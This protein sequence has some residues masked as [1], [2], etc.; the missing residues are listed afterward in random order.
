MCS[1]LRIGSMLLV[2]ALALI[3]CGAPAAPAAPPAV[4]ATTAVAEEITAGYQEAP[5][6]AAQVAAGQLP[7][8][9]ER[10]P[11]NPLVVE[12][13]EQIGV[14]GG[15]W[16]TALRGGAD[17]AWLVRTIAYENLVTWD[18][19]F[20]G[21]VPAVAE[22]YEVSDDATTFTFYLRQGMKWS[23]G[24]PFTTDDLL[25]WHELF[26]DDEINPGKDPTYA[27]GGEVVA[28]EKVDDTTVRFQ[29]AEPNGLFLLRLA[30]PDAFRLTQMPKHY[31]SQFHAAY[32]PEADNLAKEQGYEN[33]QALLRARW[34]SSG[35]FNDA[36][37][38]V[39]WA[40]K[41]TAGY[42]EATS[43]LVA[44]RNPYYYKVDTAG[45]QLP[46]IDRVVYSVGADAQALLL[47]AL[48]GEIDLMSR[49][50]NTIDNKAVLFDN[51]E[52]GAYRFYNLTSVNA[53][54]AAIM[55]NLA[56]ADPAHRELYN[57]KDFRIGLSHAIN[58]QEIIDTVFVGQ[59]VPYQV[60]PHPASEYYNEQAATQYTE[61][62]VT[63]AGEYLDK[64]GLTAK[65]GEGFRLLPDGERLT[66][67]VEVIN[68]QGD[69]VKIMELVQRHW[70]AVGVD[71]E[72]NVA[73]RSLVQA[74]I[75]SNQYDAAILWGEGGGGQ[76]FVL[77]PIWFVPMNV[78]S[79]S[80]LWYYWYIGD[81]RGEEPPAEIRQSIDLYR[82]VQATADP[83]R[84]SE[85]LQ[86]LVQQTADNFVAIGI[87]SPLDGYGIVK[88]A[89][90]NVPETMWDS[91]TW[92]QP[93]AA[94]ASQFFFAAE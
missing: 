23:D 31:L 66:V 19:E 55:L 83:A 75:D 88:N 46:Y 27:P 9:E 5:D 35:R 40:W 77:A 71:T 94:N 10:L 4:P 76:D 72:L 42:N 49:H 62:D 63:L 89:M 59:G 6:L 82:E 24:E 48:N 61:Y 45:N 60:A 54:T 69:W 56:N 11:K 67:R 8:L 57:N 36:N 85:L 20:R 3:A 87:S 43:Q 80:V 38:P 12:P 18:L 34:E 86:Q 64:A 28:L 32:N 39:L 53:N 37:M 92:P 73:D 78:H 47:N 81:E 1:R 52:Q 50:F 68:T 2:L 58:R 93:G 26:L 79:F 25:F 70:E 91:Y 30:T 29:F 21:V 14:Y 16:R 7:P 51:Q 65:D 84:R 13:V 41:L 15:V 44:E 74:N 90:R 33:W 22:R 17:N